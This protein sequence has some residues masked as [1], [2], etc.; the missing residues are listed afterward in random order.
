[1]LIATT[2]GALLAILCA[3]LLLGNLLARSDGG[4]GDGAAG[5]EPCTFSFHTAYRDEQSEE[6]TSEAPATNRRRDA[7]APTLGRPD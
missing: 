4:T 7:R 6:E 1:M 3:W 2:I 5:D